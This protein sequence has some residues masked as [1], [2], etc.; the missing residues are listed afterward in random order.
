MRNAAARTQ[1]PT[2]TADT[3]PLLPPTPVD[4]L[5]S[6]AANPD[7]P[8]LNS[9]LMVRHTVMHAKSAAEG[10]ELVGAAHRGVPWL[11]PLCDRS[12]RPPPGAAPWPPD[13]V[14]GLH[15]RVPS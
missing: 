4:T 13:G 3:I 2:L 9:I 11:H 8:G 10:V 5:E 15:A 6:E 7:V 1:P 14:G 12:V